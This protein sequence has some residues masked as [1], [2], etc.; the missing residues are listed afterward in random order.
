MK[1]EEN[2]KQIPEWDTELYNENYSYVYNYGKSLVE[3]LNPKK[4]ERILDLGCGSGKL[5]FKIN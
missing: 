1:V 2:D 5:T 4:N 3:L